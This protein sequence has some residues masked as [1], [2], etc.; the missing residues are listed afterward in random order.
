M[1][2][3]LDDRALEDLA[4]LDAEVSDRIFDKFQKLEDEGMS[5][6]EV[7]PW[8][9]NSGELLFRLKIKEDITDHRAFFDIEDGKAVIYGVFHRDEAYENSVKKEIENRIE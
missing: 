5:I 1:E 4:N 7:S 2:V 9:D 6:T 3:R 8:E